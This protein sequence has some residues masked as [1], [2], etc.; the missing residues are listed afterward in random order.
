LT[1]ALEHLSEILIPQKYTSKGAEQLIKSLAN[2][3][4][5]NSGSA[6]QILR[7]I[8]G[9]AKISSPDYVKRVFD[10]NI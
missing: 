10:K 9:L 1:L 2:I 6:R 4:D 5:V 7:A 3:L 8:Q